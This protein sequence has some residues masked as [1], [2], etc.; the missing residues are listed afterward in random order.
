MKKQVSI[1]G[2]SVEQTVRKKYRIQ[3]HSREE[4]LKIAEEFW[5]ET[6]PNDIDG[7][8]IAEI[9][10]TGENDAPSESDLKLAHNQQSN[11][12]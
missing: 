2:V 11:N 9:K 6:N 3:A 1:Y 7:W 12:D 8:D 4:A 10:V 5:D